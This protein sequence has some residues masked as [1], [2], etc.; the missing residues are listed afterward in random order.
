MPKSV[1][2]LIMIII[3]TLV[4]V[5]C[6]QLD[7]VGSSGSTACLGECGVVVNVV[8][9]D[10]IDVL[11]NGV[12]QRVR[13][14]GI[15]TPERDEVCYNEATNAN[16]AL[17]EGQ[18]VRLEVD[19]SETDRFGRLLR[20]IYVGDTFVNRQLIADGYAEVVL[21]QPD[22]EFYEDFLRFETNAARQGL[23]CHPTGIFDDGNPER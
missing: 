7:T 19:Q 13:Y 22:D 12:E 5:A 4:L 3:T 14:V 18:T 17:V 1:Y 21:Y 15:N 10:T 8:D 16:A 11:I 20:Y 2:T 23:G 6:D 9:G